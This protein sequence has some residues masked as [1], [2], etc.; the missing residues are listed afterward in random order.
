MK[1]R[2]DKKRL[3]KK[4]RG[5]G[6]YNR[7]RGTKRN[8]TREEER[9]HGNGKRS[10]DT[11]FLRASATS[12]LHQEPCFVIIWEPTEPENLREKNKLAVS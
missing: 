9:E 3:R 12:S 11:R 5:G 2:G 8:R 4:R 1:G 7:S 10:S 6:E